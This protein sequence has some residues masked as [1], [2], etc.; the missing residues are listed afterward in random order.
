M[1][2]VDKNIIL[3]LLVNYRASYQHIATRLN[4]S[5][6]AVKKRIDKMKAE[7][8]IRGG[9][10]IPTPAMMGT[11]E[12]NAI[13]NVKPGV[14]SAEILDHIGSHPLVAS[15]SVLTDGSILCF[16]HYKGAIE[17]QEIGT[18]LRSGDGVES[19]EFHTIL[20]D[21]GKRCELSVSDLKVLHSLREDLRRPINEIAKQT[22]LTPRRVRKILERLFG[23]N[24]SSPSYYINW[25]PR[26]GTPTNQVCFKLRV[27]WDLNA[28]GYTAFIVIVRHEEGVESQKLV[29]KALQNTYPME[30]WYAYASAFEP[31][32]FCI[33]L[34]SHIREANDILKTIQEI[35][36]AISLRPI[37]GY[38]TKAFHNPVDIYFDELF[39]QLDTK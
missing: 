4:L 37:Y 14:V 5:V 17:L 19:V 39:K 7:G 9:L 10:L 29:V 35:P 8:L 34:V 15:G 27:W 36:E 11:E 2:L 30:F 1:D 28:G 21:Q 3:E 20:Q 26:G 24:G 23:E 22:Q 18:F 33:F 6:N 32:I 16:G 25:E 13:I 38:P 31:V 12:W